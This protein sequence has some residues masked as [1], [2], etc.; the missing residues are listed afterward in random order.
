MREEIGINRVRGMGGLVNEV[1]E[2]G[3][4]SGRLGERI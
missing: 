4:R 2:S 1:E 3:N